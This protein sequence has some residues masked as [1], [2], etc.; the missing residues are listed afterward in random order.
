MRI[1]ASQKWYRLKL[2]QSPTL[3]WGREVNIRLFTFGIWVNYPFKRVTSISWTPESENNNPPTERETH[4]A[5]VARVA[6]PGMTLRLGY[7]QTSHWLETPSIKKT[8]ARLLVINAWKP[9]Y[10]HIW[11]VI[12][13]CQ[14]MQSSPI[15]HRCAGGVSGFVV[16]FCSPVDIF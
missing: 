13:N 2:K 12:F 15:G 16:F 8:G 3:C 5:H 4:A 9:A 1:H 6:Q 7:T 14:S 10:G 11:V